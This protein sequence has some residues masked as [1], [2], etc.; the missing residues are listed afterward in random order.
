MARGEQQARHLAVLRVPIKRT[1]CKIPVL[2]AFWPC[3]ESGSGRDLVITMVIG[4]FAKGHRESVLARLRF[5]YA[6]LWLLFINM[7]KLSSLP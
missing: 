4:S 5:D 6:I 7:P 1:L 2:F 3:F